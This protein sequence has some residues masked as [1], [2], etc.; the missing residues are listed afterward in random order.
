MKNKEIRGLSVEQLKQQV[1]QEQEAL[2]RLR[3][4]H[5]TSPI[6]NPMRIRQARKLIARMMTELAARQKTA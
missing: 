3:F 1:T 5:A 6:E 4:A 2:S